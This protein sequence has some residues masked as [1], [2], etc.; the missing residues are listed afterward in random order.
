MNV[1]KF[2]SDAALYSEKILALFLQRIYLKAF[3]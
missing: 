3:F 1:N 2:F